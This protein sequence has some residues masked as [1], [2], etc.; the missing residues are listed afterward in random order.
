MPS[1]SLVC[2]GFA[3]QAATTSVGL[4]MPNLP[5]SVVTGHVDG[6][7]TEELRQN[8]LERTLDQVV[9]NLTEQPPA[10]VPVNE[11]SPQ[12]VVFEGSFDEV[13]R[14]FYENGWSDGLPLVPPTK[15]KVEEFLGWTDRDPD[16]ELGILLP[17]N[18]RATPWNVAVNGV[19]AGCRPRL[20]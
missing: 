18:R 9:E 13:N 6:Q 14:L 15:E 1:A 20:R 3:G 16:E 4:G 11:P 10:A 17:D 8:V 5:L 7:T 2:E 12:D 19:M